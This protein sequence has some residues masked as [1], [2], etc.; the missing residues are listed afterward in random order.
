MHH[1][2]LALA[3]GEVDAGDAVRAAKAASR[4]VKS[5]LIGAITEV[6]AI[7]WPRWPWMNASSPSTRCNWGTYRFRY[8]LD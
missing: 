4:A 3:P 8:S 2:V 5:W 6:E 7:G 1:I